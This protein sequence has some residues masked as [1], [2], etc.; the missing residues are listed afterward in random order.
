[1]TTTTTPRPDVPLPDEIEMV[2]EWDSDGYRNV[3][4]FDRSVTDHAVRVYSFGSQASDGI[5]YDLA[6]HLADGDDPGPHLNSDQARELAA[7]L[8]VAAAEIDRWAAK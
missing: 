1:M 4:G 3:F 2:G 5:I 8:L 6:V 7:A